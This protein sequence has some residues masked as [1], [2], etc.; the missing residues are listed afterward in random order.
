MNQ[1]GE[2]EQPE[3]A[4]AKRIQLVV[5]HGLYPAIERAYGKD[6]LKR[7]RYSAAKMWDAMARSEG[8]SFVIFAA[9]VKCLT[10]IAW[11]HALRSHLTEDTEEG[12]EKARMELNLMRRAEAARTV[13][14][15]YGEETA[16]K[17][18]V[19]VR[20]ISQIMS[21]QP[22]ELIGAATILLAGIIDQ[23]STMLTA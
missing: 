1:L 11:E 9:Y 17:A 4:V 19:V 10:A 15:L 8:E 6:A 2:T 14:A 5:H 23:Q 21:E 20:E 7:A 13:L 22:A 3:S 12:V 16:R 18:D